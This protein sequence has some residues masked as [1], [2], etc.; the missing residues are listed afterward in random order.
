MLN[1]RPRENLVLVRIE[2]KIAR[3]EKLENSS[4]VF[5]K[6]QAFLGRFR[7]PVPDRR[8]IRCGGV[9]GQSENEDTSAAS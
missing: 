1:H 2:K 5:Q 3:F 9:M 6:D 8:G 7:L 4:T